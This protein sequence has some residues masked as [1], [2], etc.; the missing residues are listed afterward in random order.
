MECSYIA[1]REWCHILCSQRKYCHLLT[2]R[3]AWGD[4][5]GKCLTTLV[6]GTSRVLDM[7][8][9][10][11]AFRALAACYNLARLCRPHVCVALLH[12]GMP[13]IWHECIRAVTTALMNLQ[14]STRNAKSVVWRVNIQFNGR[15]SP[16]AINML[17]CCISAINDRDSNLNLRK[18]AS[19]LAERTAALKNYQH[20]MFRAA[21]TQDVSVTAIAD[22][23][24]G[25][26][27]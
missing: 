17:L 2:R 13:R 14:Q 16:A 22:T 20:Y 15:Q 23:D 9:T 3:L 6:L 24:P 1:A 21:L 10:P 8:N 19:Q 12:P 11:C 7:S 5:E 4:M 27:C 25:S 26:P 18:N